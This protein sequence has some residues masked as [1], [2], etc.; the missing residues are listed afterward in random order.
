M[1]YKETDEMRNFSA[2]LNGGGFAGAFMVSDPGITPGRNHS[3][4]SLILA[5]YLLITTCN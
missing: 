4:S 3:S 2:L 5:E 1:S